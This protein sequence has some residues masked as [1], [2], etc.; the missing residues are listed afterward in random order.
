[1]SVEIPSLKH[2]TAIAASL[3]L[4]HEIDTP[5]VTPPFRFAIFIC[6]SLPFSVDERSG[7]DLTKVFAN[8]NDPLPGEIGHW[9]RLASGEQPLWEASNSLLPDQIIPQYRSD[10]PEPISRTSISSSPT[11][12]FESGQASTEYTAT[13]YSPL[14]AEAQGKDKYVFASSLTEKIEVQSMST[15]TSSRI[16]RFHPILDSVRISIPTAHIYGKYDPYF[17]QSLQLVDM[18]KKDL[19]NAV[20]SCKPKGLL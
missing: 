3:L 10:F 12:I 9:K 8:L 16:C 5:L 1:V 14:E 17:S 15:T 19:V 18:C 13:P 11:T 7:F 2:I 20:A 6:G 4:H